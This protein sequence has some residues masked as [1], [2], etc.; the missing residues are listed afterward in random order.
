MTATQVTI[1]SVG[2]WYGSVDVGMYQYPLDQ[3]R[4]HGTHITR[5]CTTIT[6]IW[7]WG[8]YEREYPQPIDMGQ[9]QQQQAIDHDLIKNA[10]GKNSIFS[11]E[12]QWRELDVNDTTCEGINTKVLATDMPGVHVNTLNVSIE[13]GTLKAIGQRFDTGDVVERVFDLGDRYDPSTAEA[14]LTHGVLTI[15]IK[16]HEKF[17]NR[18]IVVKEAT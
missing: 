12:A 8:G 7:G 5:D 13:N 10:L 2:D 3:V 4:Y 18:T 11:A 15:R 16:L 14:S 17:K 6:P 1:N 9:G